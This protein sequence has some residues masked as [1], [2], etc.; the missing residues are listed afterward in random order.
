M[1]NG[2]KSLGEKLQSLP[3]P[4]LYSVLFVLCSITLLRPVDLPNNP[5]KPSQDF[6]EV[7]RTLPEDK[8]V[9][10]SSDWTNSTRGESAGEFKAL[11]RMLMRKNVKFCVFS[12]GDPQAPRA[13]T[14]VIRTI[15][16]E[17][18]Q[19]HER[20]YAKWNDWV[21]AGYFPGAEAI[22]NAIENN[23]RTAFQDKKDTS[24]AG[25]STP[26]FQSPVLKNVSKVSDFSTMFIVTGSKTSNIAI[27]RI[28]SVRLSMMV[29]GVMGPESRV[30]Y[31]SG[32]ITG[33]VSGLK[34]L[35]DVE[36]LMQHDYPNQKNLDNG[37][38]YYPPLHIA[39]T[40]LVFAV[41]IGNLG[42]YL[43]RK[44]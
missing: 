29:T 5:A 21:M 42:M 26:I 2:Q 22:S 33:L 35:F 30:Y 27:E 38:R 6:Y 4:A 19:N 1:S 24:D 41:I 40:L 10:I 3:K 23:F 34:G 8:P 14:D 9:L 11:L 37:A 31:D 32:Q 15:N 28:K 39:L 25:V 12:M 43:A 7:L 13:A 16:E 17:R 36:K 20:P 18:V 44:Q